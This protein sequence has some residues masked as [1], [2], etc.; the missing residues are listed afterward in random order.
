LSSSKYIYQYPISDVSQE[1]KDEYMNHITE[2]KPKVIVSTS[3]I[4]M[5]ILMPEEQYKFVVCNY[6][7]IGTAK[8][9]QIYLL[10]D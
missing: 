8:E 5:E 6:S 1:I 4:N 7:L 3:N 2:E 10:N 9:Y